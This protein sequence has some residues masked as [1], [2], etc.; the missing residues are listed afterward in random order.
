MTLKLTLLSVVIF[1]FT[2]S[3]GQ[4]KIEDLKIDSTITGFH[5]AADFQG[6]I[7]FTKNG[8]PD[9]QTINPTAFSFT[10]APGITAAAAKEQLE[11]MLT[12]SK[13]NGYTIT[14]LQTKDT[15]LSGFTAYYVSYIETDKSNNYKNM[16]FNSFVIKDDT[17][18]IFVSGDLDD[19]KYIEKF[20]RTFF[21]IKL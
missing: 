7:V 8:P 18:I 15:T 2:S 13:E 1:L 17:M 9:I 21:S 3:F 20:K 5:F 11:V 4:I 6:T 19:G 12:M 10:I 16:I 14:N